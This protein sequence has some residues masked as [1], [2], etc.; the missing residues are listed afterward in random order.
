MASTFLS[1][2]FTSTVQ[3]N[4][5]PHKAGQDDPVLKDIKRESTRG[6]QLRA[7]ND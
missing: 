7:Q 2:L 1:L 6:G 4:M 5:I 3:S